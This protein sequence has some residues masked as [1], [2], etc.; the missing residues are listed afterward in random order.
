MAP[1]KGFIS[2]S[3]PEASPNSDAQRSI[4]LYPQFAESG[5]AASEGTLRGTPGL[6]VL[7]T[8]PKSPIRGLWAGGAP[9]TTGGRLFAAAGDTLYEVFANWTYTALGTIG[10]DAGHTP[11]QIFPNGSQLFIVSAGNAYLADGISVTQPQTFGFQGTV[12]TVGT[13]CTWVSGDQFDA[14]LG[15]QQIVINGSP[16][17]VSA[18][19]SPTAITLN[20]TAGTQTGVPYFSYVSEGM[21][22]IAG[23]IVTWVSGPQFTVG[24]TVIFINGVGFAITSVQDATHLTVSVPDDQVNVPWT[25]AT[26]STIKARTGAF[27]DGYF[28]VAVPDSKQF[29]ISALFDGKSWDALDYAIK[30]SYPDNIGA[31]YAHLQELYLFGDLGRTE[32]WQ[33]TGGNS[34]SP[35]PFA[36]IPG[37]FMEVATAAPFST[38][39]TPEGVAWIGRVAEGAPQAFYAKGFRAEVI[40]TAALDAVWATYSTVADAQCFSYEM[41]KHLFWQINFPT[42]DATWVYDF[43]ASQQTGRPQW[44]EKNSYDGTATHRHR[45]RCH[46]YVFNQHVV[47]DFSNGKLYSMSSLNYDDAGQPITAVRIFPHINVERMF[48]FFS[49]LV[50][51][52]ETGVGADF[53]LTLDWSDDGGHTWFTPALVLTIPHLDS[54]LNLNFNYLAYFNRLGKAR[55]RTFRLTLVGAAKKALIDCGIEHT[56]GVG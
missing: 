49:R 7:A 14:G 43:T 9:L 24:M 8:L 11:V 31:I 50:V 38:V 3:F 39:S 54:S 51:N 27:M 42:A 52:L 41:D 4:N 47:G 2:G 46:A 55:Q 6:A 5:T 23:N 12:N 56:V 29:N 35:F 10:D 53:T 37:A 32:V 13:A 28:I 17:I 34:L 19:G 22:N 26:L 40:S 36:R 25:M 33:D 20:V 16:Y 15:A 44:H 1:V 48:Q 45:A 21:C 18:Y 30:E